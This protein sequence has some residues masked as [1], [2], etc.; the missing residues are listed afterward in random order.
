MVDD[1][2]R[3]HMFGFLAQNEEQRIEEFGELGN[4]VPPAGV[5]HLGERERDRKMGGRK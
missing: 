2:Q 3:G 4:V 5:G 1:M